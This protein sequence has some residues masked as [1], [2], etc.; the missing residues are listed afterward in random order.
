MPN[1]GEISALQYCTG[2]ILTEI[3]CY[4]EFS[5]IKICLC[6][7]HAI[8]IPQPPELDLRQIEH[9]SMETARH[10]I[11]I[12]HLIL[13]CLGQELNLHLPLQ[14]NS[15]FST[16][17]NQI[18]LPSF[19][20]GWYNIN[21]QKYPRCSQFHYSHVINSGELQDC[22]WNCTCNVI[23]SSRGRGGP[24]RKQRARQNI[25]NCNGPVQVS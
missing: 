23:N 2:T 6:I 20:L 16:R 15:Q 17:E 14:C 21:S 25:H 24:R 22:N 3:C 18:R 4:S 5:E 7:C 9:Q 8:L 10:H 13:I 1:F 12:Y 19:V 11:C